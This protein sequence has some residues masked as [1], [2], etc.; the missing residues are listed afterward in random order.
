MYPELAEIDGKEYKI[1]TDFRVGIQCFIA[2]DDDEIDDFSRALAVIGL[3]FK[4]YESI[5]NYNEA[6]KIAKKYL[7]C[8]NKY[9]RKETKIDMDFIHDEAYIKAS[10]LSDYKIDLNKLE[11]MHWYQFCELI[12]G[13]TDNS[14]LSKVRDLRNLDLSEYKDKK[15]KA[16]LMEAKASVALPIK[17]SKQEQEEIDEFEALF[18]GSKNEGDFR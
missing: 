12:S 7:T 16:K 18:E 2:I 13:L 5:Q 6:L 17:Y 8:E 10:F 15:Q 1:N 11:Y 4:D 3:L 14:I 9:Q